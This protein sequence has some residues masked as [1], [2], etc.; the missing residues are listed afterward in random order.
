MPLSLGSNKNTS[1]DTDP[2]EIEQRLRNRLADLEGRLEDQQKV[3]QMREHIQH[4]RNKHQLELE[5]AELKADQRVE[6]VKAKARSAVSSAKKKAKRER[7][8]YQALVDAV[9]ELAEAIDEADASRQQ[10]S[11]AGLDSRLTIEPPTADPSEEPRAFLRDLVARQR[12][13]EDKLTRVLA[14]LDDGELGQATT[15]VDVLED[16]V[17]DLL[18]N[19][20]VRS[21]A[22]TVIE[23]ARMFAEDPG[24]SQYHREILTPYADA[25]E[26]VLDTEQRANIVQGARMAL[27]V[28]EEAFMDSRTYLLRR[29]GKLDDHE[30]E[31]DVV[32][33]RV[34]ESPDDATDRMK[35]ALD[36][37][38]ALGPVDFFKNL[39]GELTRRVDRGEDGAGVAAW[40]LS[41]ATVTVLEDE[42]VREWLAGQS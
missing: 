38:R 23:K 5:K 8:R 22:M 13:V 40:I 24:K 36:S 15:D 34:E 33:E 37:A 26:Q 25:I 4:L 6:N 39:T 32:V 27:D 10:L 12:D 9:T 30:I 21:Q 17:K 31:V 7:K 3:R 11:D 42:T 18:T 19:P 1:D 20:E 14:A 41:D 35:A 28:V 29:S 2:D 16:R